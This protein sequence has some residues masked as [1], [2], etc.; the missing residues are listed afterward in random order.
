MYMM[1]ILVKK[2]DLNKYPLVKNNVMGSAFGEKMVNVYSE[3]KIVLNIHNPSVPSGGNMRL[4]EIPATKS[5]QIADKC[6]KDWFIND[7]EIVLF[8]DNKDLLD[9][10]SLQIGSIHKHLSYLLWF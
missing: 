5:F 9:K 4:F 10:V 3:A 8:K 1:S 2:M 7:D 6:P